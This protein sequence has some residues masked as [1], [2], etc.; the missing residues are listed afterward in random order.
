M[1]TGLLAYEQRECPFSVASYDYVV[2]VGTVEVEGVDVVAEFAG[3]TGEHFPGYVF[4]LFG[5]R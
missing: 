2:V 5:R 1:Q 4:G 3:E